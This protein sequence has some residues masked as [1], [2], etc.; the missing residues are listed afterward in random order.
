M[1]PH[2][3]TKFRTEQNKKRRCIIDW[4]LD[5]EKQRINSFLSWRGLLLEKTATA[6]GRQKRNKSSCLDGYTTF[7]RPHPR[8][9]APNGERKPTKSC[10]LN[11]IDIISS[12]GP[13]KRASLAQSAARQSHNLKVVSSSLTGSNVFV[14]FL[15]EI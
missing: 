12:P 11:T 3:V 8:D 15:L 2:A 1:L 14:P 13:E 5:R 6:G 9:V 4:K 10:Q 7:L